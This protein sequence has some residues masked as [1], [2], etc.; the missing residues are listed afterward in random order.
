MLLTG[1]MSVFV[2]HYAFVWLSMLYHF[3]VCKFIPMSGFQVYTYFCYIVLYLLLLRLLLLFPNLI[4][5]LLYVFLVFHF[6]PMSVISNSGLFLFTDYGIVRYVIFCAPSEWPT[7]KEVSGYQ[8]YCI[9]VPIDLG[10]TGRK[11]NSLRIGFMDLNP[12]HSWLN[13]GPLTIRPSAIPKRWGC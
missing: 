9:S 11:S 2:L 10:Y 4:S 13:V 3:L 6:I 12:R 8:G 5:D 1:I 7:G